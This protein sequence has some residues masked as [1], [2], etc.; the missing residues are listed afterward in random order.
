VVVHGG[1]REG[2]AK[3]HADWAME[4]I[5]RHHVYTALVCVCVCVCV[6]V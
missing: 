1:V 6:C 3:L 4:S 5:S 2:D